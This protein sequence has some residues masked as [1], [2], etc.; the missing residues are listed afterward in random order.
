M[1]VISNDVLKNI[2]YIDTNLNLYGYG[3]D[4]VTSVVAKNMNKLLVIDNTVE[5]YNPAGTGYDNQA[6][7]V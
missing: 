5:V 1:S 7:K 2:D 6:A 4:I 3:I